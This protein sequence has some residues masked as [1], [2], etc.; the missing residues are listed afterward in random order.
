MPCCSA[1]LFLGWLEHFPKM[2][3]PLV[4]FSIAWFVV[5]YL[6][7]RHATLRQTGNR[8][9]SK[10]DSS[11]SNREASDEL[12]VGNLPYEVSDQD[13][14]KAFRKFGKVLSARVIANKANGKSKGFGFVAMAT[15]PQS[16]AAI[17]GMHGKE[18][19]GRKLVVNRAK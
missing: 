9:A 2:F 18:L 4:F 6:A 1:V 15:P 10:D 13:L 5:G 3:L 19:R 14:K 8:P 17:R 16:D 11:E 7:G 12:Y